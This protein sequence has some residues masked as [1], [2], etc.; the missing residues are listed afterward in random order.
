MARLS[1][2]TVALG[3]TLSAGISAQSAAADAPLPAYNA[4]PKQTSIS[5]ISSGAYMAVQFAIAWSSLIKGVGAIA[6]GAFGCSDGSGSA[7]QSTCMIGTPAPDLTELIRHTD[8]WSQSGAIDPVTNIA[9]QKIYLFNGYNDNVVARPVS[10][11]LRAF[12]AHYLGPNLGNLFYQ[13][14]IGA[15]HSQVTLVYGNPCPEN[16]GEY[17]NNCAYDQAGVILQHI[18]G[19]LMP[20]NRGTLGGTILSFRQAEFTAPD[21]PI[22]ASMDDSGFVYVPA[23]CAAGQACVVHVA[24]HG[25]LQSAGNI[26]QDFVRHAGYNE[27]ADTNHIIVLYPQTRSL[28]VNRYGVANPNACWDWWGYLDA[29]PTEHPTY[30]L[31]SGK[32]ITAIK[33]MI[34]RLTGGAPAAPGAPSGPSGPSNALLAVDRSDTAVDLAWSAMPGTPG[35]AVFR[36]DSP[37]QPFNQIGTTA[38]LSYADTGLHPATTYRYTVVPAGASVPAGS[39]GVAAATLRKVPKCIDPGQCAVR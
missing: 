12:Y 17:I 5:G 22:D 6:G 16:G 38:G 4:A 39:Q 29:D 10:D 21:Q 14:A 15:G 18:Y 32:Q 36:S 37:S 27:W 25:C 13:T 26:Q 33:R 30:L 8:T 11:A 9:S 1:V 2:R 23:D 7:A 28:L 35:Y 3:L 24:L 19:A 31:K 34:D 20:P